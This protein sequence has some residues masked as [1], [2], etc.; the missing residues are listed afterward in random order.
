MDLSADFASAK[1]SQ[2]VVSFLLSESRM[3]VYKR[4]LLRASLRRKQLGGRLCRLASPY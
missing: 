3:V 4:H 1:N 2:P